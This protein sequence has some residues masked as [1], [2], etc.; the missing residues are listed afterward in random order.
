MLIVGFNV[1]VKKGG[2]VILI[3]GGKYVVLVL[4]KCKVES[5]VKNN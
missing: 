1:R 4:V 3:K 5:L 2:Y